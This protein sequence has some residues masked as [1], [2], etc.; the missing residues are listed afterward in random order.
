MKQTIALLA[1]VVAIAGCA[2][3]PGDSTAPIVSQR[4]A[5][6]V[7]FFPWQ[8]QRPVAIPVIAETPLA[9][10]KPLRGLLS[11]P[12]GDGPFPAV[13]L[14]HGCAGL[15]LEMPDKSTYKLLR[16]YAHRYN[17]RGYVALVL[18][19]YQARGLSNVCSGASAKRDEDGRSWD[20]YSAMRYLGAL[21]YVDGNMIIVQG[22]ANGGTT[23]L[24]AVDRE[25]P[26]SEHVAAAIALYPDCRPE[27]NFTAPVLILTG[28]ADDWMPARAC[29]AMV[30]G[31]SG[32]REVSLKVYPGAT[33]A[34][35]YPLPV[36]IDR[37]GHH[38]VFD[39]EAAEDSWRQIDAFLKRHA[40]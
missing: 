10:G 14:L 2:G 33:H 23:A 18:D 27:L 6:P 24:T 17:D 3:T 40:R 22:L 9:P 32:L 37:Q 21:G 25:F 34:F 28:A 36:R 29:E 4:P 31:N 16:E 5:L 39:P 26:V 7:D 1:L 19:S 12:A 15:E 38:E 30:A 11:K 35:D 8:W 20:V 13:I